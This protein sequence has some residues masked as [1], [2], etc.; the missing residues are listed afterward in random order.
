MAQIN[1][2]IVRTELFAIHIHFMN[3]QKKIAFRRLKQFLMAAG[4][5][6]GG[7]VP[8]LFC[9]IDLAANMDSH[10]VPISSA[11]QPPVLSGCKLPGL[12]VFYQNSSLPTI[13]GTTG[14]RT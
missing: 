8:G 10:A 9:I 14:E 13:E 4:G 2:G 3:K 5:P 7:Q 12:G 6:V 11:A 1:P